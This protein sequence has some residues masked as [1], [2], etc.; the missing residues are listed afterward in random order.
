MVRI[1]IPFA[2]DANG[3][4]TCNARREGDLA[5]LFAQ[6]SSVFTGVVGEA[7]DDSLTFLAAHGLEVGDTITIDSVTGGTGIT[8]GDE[9]VVTEV[10]SATK[11]TI[12][13]NF[14]TDITAAQVSTPRKALLNRAWADLA[15][16]IYGNLTAGPV[17]VTN[18]GQVAN[19]RPI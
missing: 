8:A 2:A 1:E 5:P 13:T 15:A 6:K 14:T 18:P 11:V 16:H 12:D 3:A 19:S 7:D 10:L 9:V 17:L 4:F